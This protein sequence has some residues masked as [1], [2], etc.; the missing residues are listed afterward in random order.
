MKRANILGAILFLAGGACAEGED[1]EIGPIGEPAAPVAVAIPEA[2]PAALPA[3]LHGGTVL[4]AG[5]QPIEVVTHQAGTINAY[6]LGTPPASPQ[7]VQI[8][9]RV[10]DADGVTRPVPLTW[11]PSASR[12]AGL[13]PGAQPVPGPLE[14]V[15][16]LGG[17]TARGL[18]P[19]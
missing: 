6:H 1:P 9:V 4:M 3:A 10:P 15:Y 2:L 18:A 5:Q 14:L 12:Y 11:D 16:V 13:L 17:Q 8:T 19:G 7:D